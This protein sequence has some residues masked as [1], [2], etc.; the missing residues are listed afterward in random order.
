MPPKI[1]LIRYDTERDDP[2]SMAGFLEKAIE[3]H[4]REEIPATF[5][6]RASTPP[7]RPARSLTC[8]RHWAC[9]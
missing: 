4:R 5:F 2:E 3:V 7:I 6:C 9:A 1:M 8:W